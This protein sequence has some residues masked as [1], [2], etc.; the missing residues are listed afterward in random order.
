MT[1][2]NFGNVAEAQSGFPSIDG[3]SDG[4]AL[5]T[6]QTTDGGLSIE[7]SQIFK[8]LG[9]GFG[10]FSRLDPGL[11]NGISQIWG[12][13]LAT[14]NIAN[15][16][17]W[18]LA[19]SS[20]VTENSST[21]TGTTL[22]PPGIFSSWLNYESETAEQ[23]CLALGPNGI[24]GN[25]YIS[26]EG[27]NQG[28]VQFRESNDYG[29]SWGIPFTI[30]DANLNKD[31]LGAYRGI[32]MVYLGNSPCVTFEVAHITPYY[33]TAPGIYP[34]LPS[35]IYFWSPAVNSGKAKKIA[36]TE[37]IPFY[38]NTG[39][40]ASYGAY[41]PLCRP[42]IGKTNSSQSNLLFIAMNAAT[43]V[44]S[45][46]SNVY[47]ATYFIESYNSGNTW[48]FPQR[49][50]PD[51]P[52]KDYRY[53]SISQTN[54]Q[55]DAGRWNVQ[56]IVQTHD[57]AGSFAPNLPPGPSDFV[58]M[59]VVTGFISEDITAN[60]KDADITSKESFSLKEN[61]PNPFNP[62]TTIKFEIHKANRF[63]LEVFNVNG[64]KVA[65]LI[66]NELISPGIKEVT[67]DGSDLS[68]GIYFYTI[69]AGEYKKTGRMFLVK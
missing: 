38:P 65:T 4:S 31:S 42:A 6:M 27:S 26:Q 30:F 43:S 16:V 57:Y 62:A 61:Y 63:T 25:A 45:A 32:S 56:M 54:A 24:I 41:T 7:R 23:Y 9:P 8:D 35:Y 64:Q 49:I 10:T 36:G 28:D 66:N 17:K 14:G 18:V 37:Y 33:M 44:T 5:I 22:V 1:W 68:S 67:F 48:L 29:L 59:R 52:L 53:V 60:I 15:P 58:S 13:I 2:D 40:E 55:N 11:V 3:L 20:G 12:R 46:D 69:S 34:R 21:I 50:T 51:T 19:N 39:P 47:Y